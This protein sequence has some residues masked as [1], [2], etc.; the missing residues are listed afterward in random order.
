MTIPDEIVESI[1]VRWFGKDVAISY[2]RKH[3]PEMCAAIAPSL[4]D[5]TAAA[6]A[7]ERE[8]LF[9]LMKRLA[10]EERN[11]ETNGDVAHTERCRV[12]A[13]MLEILAHKI[14]AGSKP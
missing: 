9:A 11:T 4:P 10:V 3:I 12:R 6:V 13:S 14:R 2:I 5:L 1:L 8:V 7:A